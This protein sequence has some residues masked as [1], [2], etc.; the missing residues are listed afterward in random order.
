MHSL[1]IRDRPRTALLR[2]SYRRKRRNLV[3]LSLRRHS[4]DSPKH[5]SASY[6]SAGK[7]KHK[8]RV[9]IHAAAMNASTKLISNKYKEKIFLLF[10]PLC[11]YRA[12]RISVAW[13]LDI[14]P[15]VH[16]SY[17]DYPRYSNKF[18]LLPV[19]LSAPPAFPR[20]PSRLS[21]FPLRPLTVEQL[22]C[23][24]YA[25]QI[26]E[27]LRRTPW[28]HERQSARISSSNLFYRFCW[29]WRSVTRHKFAKSG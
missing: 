18:S 16:A 20:L 11:P 2:R 28:T 8:H 22:E 7:P 29:E 10:R 13:G 14:T 19:V 4:K 17:W 21:R 15:V 27:G 1:T 24:R 9:G 6:T 12:R 5:I 23:A 26:C 25:R 3:V